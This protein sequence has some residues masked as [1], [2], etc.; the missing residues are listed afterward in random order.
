[1]ANV[2]GGAISG[3]TLRSLTDYGQGLASTEYANAFGRFQTDRTN[4]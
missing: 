2:G 3:N 1:M 4:I